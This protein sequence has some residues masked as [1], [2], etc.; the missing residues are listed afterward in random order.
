M[1]NRTSKTKRDYRIMLYVPRELQFDAS[2]SSMG[3]QPFE[4]SL[5]VVQADD[6]VRNCGGYD[7][8]ESAPFDNL[9]FRAQAD[10]KEQKPYGWELA[11][12]GV[13]SV[14]LNDCTRMCKMLK[15][16]AAIKFPVSASTYG[17]YIQMTCAALGVEGAVQQGKSE[18]GG[19][20]YDGD[21]HVTWKTGEIQWLVDR[22]ISEFF[23]KHGEALKASRERWS[24]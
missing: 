9:M 3:I 4:F 22:R 14:D 23:E 6:K 13:Y 5:V 11:Y 7:K 2:R 21:S 24:A 18:G 8:P 17:Q 16:I 19:Y 10:G 12:R 20:G 1:A 15:R